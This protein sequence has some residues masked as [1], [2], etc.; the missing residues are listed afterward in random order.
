MN[1]IL[2]LFVLALF[3]FTNSKKISAQT[4]ISNASFEGEPADATMPAGWYSES[5][6]TTPDILPG[7]W[8]VYNEASEGDTYIGLITRSDGSFESIGQRLEKSLK[9]GNCYSFMIDLSYS[10]NYSGFNN[11]LYM[12]IWISDSKGKR[13]QLIFKSQKIDN[14]GWETHK[15][16]FQ[17]END[18]NYII[19]EAFINDN[20]SEY[21]GNILID[22]IT[23]ISDCNRA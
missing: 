4:A 21:K 10:D 9:K 11:P 7:F 17:P 1:N 14:L 16:K 5:E 15:V 6:G 23:F 8:G 2:N 19:L 3:L 13:Q 12:K 18:V 22:N 20:S